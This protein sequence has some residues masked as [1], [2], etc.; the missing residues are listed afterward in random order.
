MA[1]ESSWDMR[2]SGAED[3]NARRE[4]E[5]RNFG[6][7]SIL[8][9]RSARLAKGLPNPPVSPTRRPPS[10]TLPGVYTIP[11]IRPARRQKNNTSDISL[12]VAGPSTLPGYTRQAVDT[13]IEFSR[14]GRHAVRVA[15][16]RDVPIPKRLRLSEPAGEEG[17]LGHGVVG[18]EPIG[19][20]NSDSEDS[21]ASEESDAEGNW[22]DLE[23][24]SNPAAVIDETGEKRE[25]KRKTYMSS[26][27]WSCYYLLEAN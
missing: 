25:S 21:L 20:A 19:G 17:W 24:D 7:T 26:V 15:E 18:D 2:A 8:S 22:H 6:T 10:Q 1:P 16:G 9:P 14:T 27:R 4:Y 3:Y 23:E 11:A 13:T 12:P 5:L